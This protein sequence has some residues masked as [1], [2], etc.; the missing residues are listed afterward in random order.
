MLPPF[1]GLVSVSEIVAAFVVGSTAVT[2]AV[3]SSGASP[4]LVY[5]TQIWSPTSH[6]ALME[7]SPLSV[8]VL[9]VA[10]PLRGE[11]VVVTV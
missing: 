5:S 8:I 1:F 9:R 4:M 11:S 7:P 6:A 2:V 10:T 3:V